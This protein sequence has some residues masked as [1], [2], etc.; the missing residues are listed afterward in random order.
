MLAREGI[1]ATGAELLSLGT[2]GVVTALDAGEVTAAFVG[3]PAASAL[4]RDAR[5]RLLIDLK[6]P[7]AVADALGAPTVHAAVFARG[8]RRPSDRDLAAFSRAV[9]AAQRLIATEK[10]A[11]LVERL[12]KNVA[13][14]DDELVR[15]VELT[16]GIYLPNGLTTA[17]A[18][19][20]TIDI[21]RAHVALPRALRVPKPADLLYLDPARRTIRR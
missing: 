8:D 18:L 16:Q 19:A 3:E 14:A 21:V 20:H 12:P 4:V 7:R 6:S 15:R 11:T 1:R 9:L 2:R 5:A 17:D 13:A 10:A